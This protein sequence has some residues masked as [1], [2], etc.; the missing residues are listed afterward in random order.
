MSAASRMILGKDDRIVMRGVSLRWHSATIG[1]H[2]F[3][4]A[5]DPETTVEH[6][7]GALSAARAEGCFTCDEGHFREQRAMA[8]LR[9]DAVD[10]GDVP[11][12]ELVGMDR[13]FLICRLVQELFDE[14]ARLKASRHRPEPGSR[15]E[16]V[17]KVSR[18]D[19]GLALAQ[20]LVWPKVEEAENERE[21]AARQRGG[22]VTVVRGLAKYGPQAIRTWLKLL[23]DADWDILALRSR[24]RYCGRREPQIPPDVERLLAEHAQGYA[25]ENRPTI[26][27]CH[28]DLRVAV[29][30]LNEN[31]PKRCRHAVPSIKALTARIRLLD[32]FEV[33]AA[34]HGLKQARHRFRIL[35]GG[36]GVTRPGE[37][38]EMDE[39]KIHLHTAL[40][41]ARLTHLL[42][43]E[44][45]ALTKNVRPW[46]CKIKDCRTK[47]TLGF[48]VSLESSTDSVLA[49]IRM[50][51]S[52]KSSLA[53]AVGAQSAWDMAIVPEQI[54]TD[55]GPTMVNRRVRLALAGLRIDHGR[56]IAGEPS[57]RGG[58]ERDFRTMGARGALP[59]FT[60]RTFEHVVARGDYP[61][62]KRVSV[63]TLAIAE[64]LLRMQIDYE[65]NQPH[66]SLGGETPRHCW[67]R[68]TNQYGERPLPSHDTLRAVF[69][70]EVG[71]VLGPHGIAVF[72]LHY[73]SRAL[74]EWHR[75]TTHARRIQVRVDP[76]D[77][78]RVSA[79]LG[80]AWVH[81]DCVSPGFAGKPLRVWR[82]ACAALRARFKGGAK[83][84]E[85]VLLDAIRTAQAA[86]RLGM[87]V[88]G[89]TEAWTTGEQ[90][91]RAERGL[92][93]GWVMPGM[94]EAPPLFDGA[95]AATGPVS[96]QVATTAAVVGI[97]DDGSL[98]TPADG[99]LDD[100]PQHPDLPDV[101]EPALPS[102]AEE[103]DA[104]APKVRVRAAGKPKGRS[105]AAGKPKGQGPGEPHD[106]R[107]TAEANWIEV[108]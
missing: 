72:G 24:Y 37:R 18:S 19:V 54:V 99:A 66:S 67:H 17:L 90:I 108:E 56:T 36:L 2:V 86:A 28:E 75:S 27:L 92:D 89:L 81:L 98:D 4:L 51:V 1:G 94:D 43:K 63:T 13:K 107:A 23:D 26:R 8:R 31:L 84:S 62:D 82:D 78:G 64:L 70:V 65:H 22:T 96:P 97:E 79:R 105:R 74:Q 42:P 16:C 9:S 10:L 29:D 85:P 71:R 57:M 95:V 39:A 5:D 7:H 73:Q 55:N 12:D 61:A 91:D 21:T 101:A 35:T 6:S 93:M 83:I 80:D 59:R 14:C 69:G 103:R 76:E 100:M 44:A 45:L 60:A 41:K 104:A 87:T 11:L 20:D 33:C 50:M 46:V 32:P 49:A 53:A 38:V 47:V 48:A 34:R 25:S 58:I 88:F 40:S 68:L 3:R 102:P 77:L 106:P 15:E 30:D 52:D